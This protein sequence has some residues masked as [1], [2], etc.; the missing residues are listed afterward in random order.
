MA[1]GSLFFIR[2]Q[3]ECWLGLQSLRLDEAGGCTS[4]RAGKWVMADGG[5]P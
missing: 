5:E 2:S 4:S 3:S 1:S